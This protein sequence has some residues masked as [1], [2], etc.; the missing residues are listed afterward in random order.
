[1]TPSICLYF[2]ADAMQR[3]MVRGLQARGVDAMTAHEA[4]MAGATD[5]DQL[6]FA[7]QQGR[8]LFS[9]NA[10][11]FFRIHTEWL[12][13]GKSHRGIIL[14]PQQQYTIGERIRRILKLMSVRSAEEMENRVEFLSDWG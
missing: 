10:S 13:Q 11:D 12:T 6:E 14:A 4:D 2:D 7:R 9:F 1:V 8:V 5:E 3:A